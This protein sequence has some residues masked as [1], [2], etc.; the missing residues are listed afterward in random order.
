MHTTSAIGTYLEDESQATEDGLLALIYAC[1]KI[2]VG[3]GEIAIVNFTYGGDG[4]LIF[5]SN[6]V[7]DPFIYDR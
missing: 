5:T 1:L 7:F 2:K 4:V 3:A 6:T